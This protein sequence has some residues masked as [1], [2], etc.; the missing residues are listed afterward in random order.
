MTDNIFT[1]R[2][3][4]LSAVIKLFTAKPSF[5]G[6]TKRLTDARKGIVILVLLMLQACTSLMGPVSEDL[7]S[8]SIGTTI[9]DQ[10]V[11][12]RAK[13][14]LRS[15]HPELEKAHVSVTSFNGVILLTGQVPSQEAR[16]AATTAVESL[17][18][19]KLVHNELEI[20]GPISFMA[21]TN[22]SW[23]TTKVKT[24]MITDKESEGGRIK[25]ITENGVVYLM[26]LLSRNEADA[27]VSRA[28]EIFGV[29]KIVKVFEYIN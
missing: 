25:V 27:A 15:A 14:N 19:V 20:A 18:K 6:R 17:R 9:D 12:T 1:A 4:P 28:R 13:G 10:L 23:L 2:I 5:T 22:D 26:G 16:R 11:E 3:A 8:R 24:A 29:Q 21:R 7:G